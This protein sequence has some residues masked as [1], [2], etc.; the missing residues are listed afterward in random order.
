[1]VY[2]FLEHPLGLL[3]TPCTQNGP[4]ALRAEEVG[5][6]TDMTEAEETGSAEAVA[7]IAEAAAAR[8]SGEPDIGF[9]TTSAA[10][11]VV[12]SLGQMTGSS[13]QRSSRTTMAP[14]AVEARSIQPEVARHTWQGTVLRSR[15]C[16]QSTSRRWSLQQFL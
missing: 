7:D 8:S 13:E 6:E 4:A 11:M 3:L 2:S 14:A 15:C 5:I 9:G 12:G 16:G 10:P 1:M